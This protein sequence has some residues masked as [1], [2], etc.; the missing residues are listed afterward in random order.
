ML[1]SH[2]A[3]LTLLGY[4]LR[5]HHTVSRIALF[6]GMKKPTHFNTIRTLIRV[7]NTFDIDLDFKSSLLFW[8]KMILIH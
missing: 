8:S 5:G 7:L 6:E 1:R 4:Y 3:T 2:G